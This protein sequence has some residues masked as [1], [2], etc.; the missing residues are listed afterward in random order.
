MIS[1]E[2]GEACKLNLS[3]CIYCAYFH[4]SWPRC[5]LADGSLADL[6]N[7]PIPRNNSA[8]VVAYGIKCR[9][10]LIII[11]SSSAVGPSASDLNYES[12][13][14]RIRRN[15]GSRSRGTLYESLLRIFMPNA[16]RRQ[17]YYSLGMEKPLTW[18]TPRTT[19]KSRI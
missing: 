15:Y 17:I 14:R 6:E 1:E 16:N 4:E 13:V 2:R 18:V 19:R 7:P 11:S 12:R 9:S 3:H 8:S 5:C 10:L